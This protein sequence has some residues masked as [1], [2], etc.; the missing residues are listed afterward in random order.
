[1]W[2]CDYE[3]I[4][5]AKLTSIITWIGAPRKPVPIAKRPFRTSSLPPLPNLLKTKIL[6]FS[7]KNTDIMHQLWIK[8]PHRRD[9]VTTTNNIQVTH[10]LIQVAQFATAIT[11]PIFMEQ[12]STDGTWRLCHSAAIEILT[13]VKRKTEEGINFLLLLLKA[14]ASAPTPIAV[15]DATQKGEQ[16]ARR[17]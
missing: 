6:S 5:R 12:M 8:T 14:A 1:M 17:I 15:Q 11:F 4:K 13:A 9:S 7:E 10:F 16:G 3:Y 2:S